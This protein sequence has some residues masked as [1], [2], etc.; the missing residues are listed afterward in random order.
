MIRTK[1]DIEV[2]KRSEEPGAHYYYRFAV[3]KRYLKPGVPARVMRSSGTGLLSV[4]RDKAWDDFQRFTGGR[5]AV[6]GVPVAERIGFK[7]PY[8]TVEE[9]LVHYLERAP[10]VLSGAAFGYRGNVLAI[11]RL[12]DRCELSAEKVRLDVLTADLW[13]QWVKVRYAEAGMEWPKDA[14]RPSKLNGS[15]NSEWRQIKAIFG[16]RSR[17]D[18]FK[19][20]LFPPSLEGFLSRPALRAA[21]TRYQPIPNLA[22]MDAAFEAALEPWARMTYE[23]ARFCG[24]RRGEI[25]AARW[26]WVEGNAKDGW[27]IRVEDRGGDEEE[28]GSKVKNRKGRSIPVSAQRMARWREWAESDGLGGCSG[29]MVRRADVG[30][31][32]DARLD[33]VGRDVSA[34]VRVW[35]PEREK[36]LHELRKA[37]GSEVLR[38]TASMAMCAEFLGDTI[39][40][41]EAHYGRVELKGRMAGL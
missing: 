8:R 3:P 22:Q 10:A 38:L 2:F 31:G 41:A 4:A 35:L 6:G 7:T 23:L 40:V 12:L 20:W 33:L 39:A 29:W 32:R 15:L 13:E 28:G 19:G 18:V 16:A 24:L 25:V 11:R 34:M 9:A 1:N 30:E 17:R 27:L 14:K 5:D 36:S 37:A 21:S 26:E